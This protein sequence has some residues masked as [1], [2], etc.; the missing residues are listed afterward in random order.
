MQAVRCEQNSDGSWTAWI[1]S[2]S[3]TGTYA[4]CVA[5]VRAN[6]EEL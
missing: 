6:G 1:F 5:W 3:F 2:V 4:E